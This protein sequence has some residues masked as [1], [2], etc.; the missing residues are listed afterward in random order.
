MLE[1][2]GT[3]R[4]HVIVVERERRQST[5]E[6]PFG[7]GRVIT[8]RRA[9]RTLSDPCRV[10][11]CDSPAARITSGI[12]KSTRLREL[13]RPLDPG[14]LDEFASSCVLDTLAL[15]DEPTGQRPIAEEWL[16]T[17]TDQQDAPV[18]VVAT[19]QRDVGSECRTGELVFMHTGF[20]P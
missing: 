10:H 16:C 4:Y 19:E 9:E 17:S 7:L 18:S 12:G 1:L 13:A 14:L 11:E 5:D 3:P 6:M 8:R 2:L 15:I 20:V